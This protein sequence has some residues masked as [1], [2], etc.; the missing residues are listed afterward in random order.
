MPLEPSSA[1]LPSVY[2]R[3]PASMGPEAFAVDVEAAL[4]DDA[5]PLVDDLDSR[6]TPAGGVGRAHQACDTAEQTFRRVRQQLDEACRTDP[7]PERHSDAYWDGAASRRR[8]PPPS[9]AGLARIARWAYDRSERVIAEAQRLATEIEQDAQRRGSQ[10][11]TDLVSQRA[12]LLR[13]IAELT[14]FAERYHAALEGSLR[15]QE[16]LIEGTAP[17]S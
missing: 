3:P 4:P 7:V 6:G 9:T 10:A 17:G 14:R 5:I 1:H 15:R 2:L 16:H 11:A 8:L 12:G 13:D